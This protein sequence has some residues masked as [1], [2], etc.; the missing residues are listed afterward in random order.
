MARAEEATGGKAD[1]RATRDAAESV[2]RG[3]GGHE[4]F[5]LLV[6]LDAALA[7]GADGS[8]VVAQLAAGGRSAAEIRRL[9]ELG[10]VEA[11]EMAE[12]WRY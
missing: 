3:V 11:A 7:E 4:E 10:C 12:V 6:A 1:A 2:T 5:G 9:R 8:E